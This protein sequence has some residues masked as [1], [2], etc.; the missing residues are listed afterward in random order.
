M[1]VFISYSVHD[2]EFVKEFAEA[3][4]P[5][6]ESLRYWEESKELGE[7][8]W[9]SIFSWIDE[10]DLVLAVITDK[11]INRAMAVGNEIGHARAKGRKVI[12]L[13]APGINDSQLGCLKGVT[14]QRIDM[15]NPKPAIG[16]IANEISRMKLAKLQ[17][18]QAD[19]SDLLVIAGL[20][21]LVIWATKK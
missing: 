14:Y 4:K 7:D 12:P 18:G 1:K 20:V 6:V 5:H 16:A 17:A 13:V 9:E 15:D 11:T 3:L 8:A 21:A 19:L 10:A 2:S